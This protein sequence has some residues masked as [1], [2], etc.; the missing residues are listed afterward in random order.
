MHTK[1]HPTSLQHISRILTSPVN[2]SFSEN[3][4][5]IEKLSKIFEYLF[6]NFQYFPKINIVVLTL[7]FKKEKENHCILLSR[8]N[9]VYYSKNNLATRRN[10]IH[11][12][13]ANKRRT[14]HR[15]PSYG[16]HLLWCS[17]SFVP[18]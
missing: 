17:N 4:L 6:N 14:C 10:V 9:F 13:S 3:Y 2:T 11:V 18:I 5:K 12:Q 8:V 1:L 15:I 16:T 7:F